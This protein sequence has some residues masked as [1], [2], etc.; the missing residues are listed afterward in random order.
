M[1][2]ITLVVHV[3][4]GYD[5]IEDK[6]VECAEQ[7]GFDCGAVLNIDSAIEDTQPDEANEVL[8]NQCTCDQGGSAGCPRHDEAV[9]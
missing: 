1:R 3:K 2:T 9:P 8:A 5:G 7:V 6:L 4:D